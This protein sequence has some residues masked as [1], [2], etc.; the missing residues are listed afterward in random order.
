M[1]T[2]KIFLGVAGNSILALYLVTAQYVETIPEAS[3]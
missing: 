2:Y 3:E 1:M